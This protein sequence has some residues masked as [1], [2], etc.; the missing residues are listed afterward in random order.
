MP[1][2]VRFTNREPLLVESADSAK[3]EAA[4]F[5]VRAL[6]SPRAIA[7]FDARNVVEAQV[8]RDGRLAEIV[9]GLGVDGANDARSS[10]R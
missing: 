8:F 2:V 3:L 10:G 4:L 5:I 9:V 7:L 1:V 6:W